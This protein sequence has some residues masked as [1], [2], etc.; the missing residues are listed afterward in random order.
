[1]IVIADRFP[2][3]YAQ[4]ILNQMRGIAETAS[5]RARRTALCP[6][7]ASFGQHPKL[8]LQ[9]CEGAA[10]DTRQPV[11]AKLTVSAHRNWKSTIHINA[12]VPSVILGG[13]NHPLRGWGRTP[14]AGSPSPT[15]RG[16]RARSLSQP[17]HLDPTTAARTAKHM[18]TVV[19][20]PSNQPQKETTHG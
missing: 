12:L 10:P 3:N 11:W 8:P 19:F 4:A 6:V 15:H 16:F 18:T 9:D 17:E 5:S 20:H 14:Q 2:Q 7:A 1:M 13:E